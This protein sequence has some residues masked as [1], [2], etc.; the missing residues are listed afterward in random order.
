MP[1]NTRPRRLALAGGGEACMLQAQRMKMLNMSMVFG[2]GQATVDKCEAPKRRGSMLTS[3]CN[4]MQ[5]EG[6]VFD[7]SMVSGISPFV[8]SRSEPP[9]RL[10]SMSSD[11]TDTTEST[12]S[13]TPSNFGYVAEKKATEFLGRSKDKRLRTLKRH[14]DIHG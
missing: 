9:M 2:M 3:D 14:M 6:L 5:D 8:D 12:E 4:D 10:E 11:Y 1:T 7:L 13:S